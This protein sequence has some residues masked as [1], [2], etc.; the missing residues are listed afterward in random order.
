M[1]IYFIILSLL[2][3]LLFVYSPFFESFKLTN[4]FST[5]NPNLI[6]CDPNST[7]YDP[8]SINKEPCPKWSGPLENSPSF[9]CKDCG[10]PIYCH[11]PYKGDNW[12]HIFVE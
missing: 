8:N 6:N 4:D 9:I 1:Y 5:L 10:Y 11:G 7:N 2:I 12:R 3:F